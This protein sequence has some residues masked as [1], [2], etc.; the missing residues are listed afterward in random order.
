MSILNKTTEH[1][2]EEGVAKA[3]R[4]RFGLPWLGFLLTLTALTGVLATAG[5][6][7]ALSDEVYANNLVI[8]QKSPVVNYLFDHAYGYAY[9]PVAG[10]GA[11]GLGMSFG[12]GRVYRRGQQTGSASLVKL[13]LGAQLGGQAY[14]EL[15]F[16][17]DKR[18]YD[19]FTS[20]SFELDATV[21]AVAIIAGANAQAGTSGTN[22]GATS[23]PTTGI[24]A[25]GQYVNGMTAFTHTKGGL[26]LEAGIGGQK[27]FVTRR[28]E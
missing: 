3:A 6:S 19:E 5:T 27:F 28:V 12:K 14:S 22:A 17:E 16:F 1:Q 24:Q 11:A 15:I 21:S 9:F 4:A 26:M 23:G 25:P 18:A 7:H 2:A 13:S 20:G 8:F 10:R